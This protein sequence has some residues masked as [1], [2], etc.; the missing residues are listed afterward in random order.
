MTGKPQKL[1]QL[2]SCV[3][4]QGTKVV[5]AHGVFDVLH[6]G[7][8]A[9]FEAAKKYGDVL[10]VTLTSDRYVNKG[11]GRPY[12]SAEVRAK[13]LAALD[14]VD[15]VA[16]SDYPTAVPAIEAIRP[17]FYVK[18]PDYKDRTKD[19]TGEIYNEENAVKSF[20][21]EL[22][23]T[24]DITFSSSTLVNKYFVDWTDDQRKII[25]TV[26]S[27][28][29]ESR[30]SEILEDVSRLS[31]C[32]VGEPITDTYR[33]CIPEN[34][35]SKSPSISARHQ[36]EE[37]Y[38]GG[39]KAIANH[40]KGFVKEV[41]EMDPG[42]YPFCQKVRYISLDRQQRIF[43]VTH[44]PSD[45][46]EL[47]KPQRLCRS[48]LKSAKETDM[49]IVADFG[50]RLFEGEVL[51]CLHDIDRFIGLNVQ[52]NSS[53]YGFN[54]YKK[55]RNFNYLSI[56]T[57]EARLAF[58]DRNADA[59]TLALNVKRDIGN[60]A[61]S[62]TL[63]SNG[64][65]Y[66]DKGRE[67]LSP[68]FTKNIVDATGAGDAYFALTSCLVKVRCDPA[69]IPFMGNVFAGL[70]TQILGNKTPVTK[71]SFMKAISAILK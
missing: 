64:S 66:L 37:N 63:G 19:V 50:H 28:G 70:K 15:H 45:S 35:S 21:G 62:M 9:Y 48:I 18:G 46:W 5:H 59:Y 44:L 3:L 36:Y 7:H 27:L 23:F 65:Y 42:H 24:D 60:R 32:V 29:G 1:F 13:M 26:K 51:N 58:H 31:V 47:I 39:S 22:V 2:G 52:T 30:I 53:N 12:F 55:H 40:L 11:P 17:D 8:L 41:M 20:G 67:F 38:E 6:A 4:K 25:E 14:I 71:A 10:V 34:I 68:A 49:T 33:F 56:D 57:R 16:I 43:E 61:L 54:V 69:L